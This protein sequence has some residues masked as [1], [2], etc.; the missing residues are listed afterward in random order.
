MEEETKETETEEVKEDTNQE[1]PETNQE[2]SQQPK[3]EVLTMEK[4]ASM[5]EQAKRENLQELINTYLSHV[6]ETKEEETEDEE[7][8]NVDDYKF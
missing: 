4:V 5:I 1:Q 2:D 8:D 3:E 6:P 7:E